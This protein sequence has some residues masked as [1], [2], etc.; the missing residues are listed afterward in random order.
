MARLNRVWIVAAL[1]AVLLSGCALTDWIAEKTGVDDAFTLRRMEADFETYWS[2]RE[3]RQRA[4]LID[5]VL[6]P[7]V[8][9][10]LEENFYD[11]S[12][13]SEQR[14]D[15]QGV[16]AR[17]KARF[18]HL[19]ARAAI[20]AAGTN[21]REDD[22]DDLAEKLKSLCTGELKNDL[23][24]QSSTCLTMGL[25]EPTA[26]TNRIERLEREWEFL[27]AAERD[28]SNFD[29]WPALLEKQYQAFE[30]PAPGGSGA[31]PSLEA[32]KRESQKSIICVLRNVGNL[33]SQN[34][35]EQRKRI[36]KMALKLERKFKTVDCY[37]LARERAG[38]AP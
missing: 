10:D 27:T 32:Y 28:R 3:R 22:V 9:K 4:N 37:K 34:E 20:G 13:R 16:D 15:S 30:S 33:Y 6:R 18:Y 21:D 14:A 7:L 35:K 24:A 12:I 31:N 23:R 5:P 17:F 2:E 38:L 11:L 1:L 26:I 8:L 25:L 36:A 19:A 29:S